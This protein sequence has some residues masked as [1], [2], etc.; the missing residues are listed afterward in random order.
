M[1]HGITWTRYL[2]GPDGEVYRLGP[3]VLHMTMLLKRRTEERVL[4]RGIKIDGNNLKW[5]SARLYPKLPKYYLLGNMVLT[6]YEMDVISCK[7]YVPI[8][9]SKQTYEQLRQTDISGMSLQ[10]V[11]NLAGQL[12]VRQK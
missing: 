9:I 6:D 8:E 10:E 3:E 2:W 7:R 5:D 1:D 11:Q 4:V 12:T